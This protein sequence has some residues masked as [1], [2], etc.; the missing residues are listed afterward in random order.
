MDAYLK[1]EPPVTGIKSA[2]VAGHLCLD[3]IPDLSRLPDSGLAGM[4]Q[5]GHLLEVGQAALSTGGAVSNTGL[6]LHKLGI[7]TRLVGK[8]GKDPLGAAIRAVLDGYDPDLSAGIL[9]DAESGSSYTVIINPPGRDRTFWH[10]PGANNTFCADDVPYDQAARA[11]LFHFG[12]PPIMRRMF[13]DGGAGL[14]E[15]LRR[16]K[17][18]GVTTSL[19]LAWPDPNSEAGRADWNRI[20]TAALPYVDIFTPSADE[21]LFMLHRPVYERLLAGP[22]GLLENVTPALLEELSAGLFDLGVKVVLIKVGDR[23]AYLHTS[24]VGSLAA[25]GRAAPAEASAWA[26]RQMW[27]PCFQVEVAGTTGSGDATIAG[28]LAALLRGLGPEEAMTAA[29]AVG[30]CNVEAPDA[31]SGIRSWEAT[32]AR[33]AAGWPRCP[34]TTKAEG[35]HWQAESQMLVCD[36]A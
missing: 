24:T 32:M 12:Y 29:V 21:L 17:A 7:P 11:D 6:A 10:Y 20:L 13:V 31:L 22:G 36:H 9:T 34:V 16:A 3:I 26:G 5:P 4:L 30:A 15:L 35:W 18:T 19:D 8:V 25:M 27:A 2:I 14:V 23:G 33:L 28:F 1:T